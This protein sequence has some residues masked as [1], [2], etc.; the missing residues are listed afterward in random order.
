MKGNA[1]L[2]RVGSLSCAILFLV[3]LL[4]C[5]GAAPKFSDDPGVAMESNEAAQVGSVEEA[6]S[7]RALLE[8]SEGSVGLRLIEG[9]SFDRVV[10]QTP[11]VSPEFK[12][13]RLE[14]PDRVVIDLTNHPNRSNRA[15][16]ASGAKYV[17]AVRLGDHGSVGRVVLDLQEGSEV[18]YRVDAEGES[19]AVTLAP[20]P[21]VLEAANLQANAAALPAAPA[22]APPADDS[23]PIEEVELALPASDSSPVE[24]TE[25]AAVPTSDAAKSALVGLRI[26]SRGQGSNALVAEMESAGFYTFK[27]SAQSEYVLTL[28]DV[29][30]SPVIEK[31]IVAPQGSGSIRAARPIAD[32]ENVVVRIFASP[33]ALLRVQTSGSKVIVGARN[34]VASSDESSDMMAQAD[35]GAI[36]SAGQSA[37][38]E[39]TE[40]AASTKEEDDL[41]RSLGID[42]E[43]TG[44]LISLDL[45][46]TDIDNALRIIAE[47]SNLNIIASQDVA[48]KVTLR[49][50]DVPW[51]QALDVILKTNGLDKVQ[52]GNVI[53]IAPVDKLRA[54]RE[55]LKEAQTAAEDLEPL[56]VKYIRVSYAKASAMQPLVDT[57]L[58]ERGTVAYDERSNQLIIKD[59]KRGLDD[60]TAL[61]EKLDLRTPQVLIETQIVEATRGFVRE[62]GSELG[63]WFLRTPE[64]GNAFGGNFPNSMAIG[65]SAATG[66][67]NA[68]VTPT[69]SFFPTADQSSAVSFLFGSAD[70]TTGLNLRLSAAE[71]EGNIRI[72]SRPS[73][74]VT[75]NTP[76]VIKSVEKLRIKLPSGGV[77]VATGQGA[78]AQG[79]GGVATEVVEVGIILNVTAQASP[80][81]YVLLDIQAKSSTLGALNAGVDDIPPEIERSA[82]STVLVSSGQTFA[83]GGIYRVS[84]NDQF[85]GVPFLKDIP[86]FGHFFRSSNV[87]NS[88][89]EL[90]FFLTP[91]IIEGSF[92]DAAMRTVL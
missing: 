26:E 79:V 81:Y 60:V 28:E 83:M 68:S 56:K 57:V 4:A 46:D 91:R 84:E 86:F 24:A 70:G 42:S 75:N 69:G 39:K 44:R 15:I 25:V 1:S 87:R 6:V 64:T 19:L 41:A 11:H 76:A 38:G 61:I 45:Q 55:A 31:A 73:V 12:V 20:T 10:I 58:T 3:G 67:N 53:R 18:S 23:H 2:K 47:V 14:A 89:E 78:S 22:A 33:E 88:D 13:S 72:V 27:R 30:L 77:S 85:D 54:E 21:E 7:E 90:I 43:F 82:N 34:D 5:S 50:I 9:D 49:L 40:A 52:E 80:D 17:K 48:G 35:L 29:Q 16:D 8:A 92:D 36:E 63:F 74:A 37:G 71:K 59:I 51:D 32:G 65:G 62:L 66:E